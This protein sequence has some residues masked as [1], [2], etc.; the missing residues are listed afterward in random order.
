MNYIKPFNEAINSQELKDFCEMN[1]AYL[2]DEGLQVN[3]EQY[4]RKKE[5]ITRVELQPTPRKQWVEIKDH[6]MPFL[7]RISN[8][9]VLKTKVNYLGDDKFFILEVQGSS[10]S[11]S[12]VFLTGF[13]YYMSYDQLENLSN[14]LTINKITL[15]V[16]AEKVSWLK[17]R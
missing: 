5:L 15:L 16:G 7:H 1:L 3:V 8:M 11:L 13:N 17:K 6:I 2:M 14:T 12:N 10:Y 9:Y 4:Y